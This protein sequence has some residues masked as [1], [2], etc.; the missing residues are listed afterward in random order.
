MNNPEE[1]EFVDFP[2]FQILELKEV[3]ERFGKREH[4]I[5]AVWYKKSRKG[6]TRVALGTFK[7]IKDSCEQYHAWVIRKKV[8]KKTKPQLGPESILDPNKPENYKIRINS[9]DVLGIYFPSKEI[10]ENN[11]LFCFNNFLAG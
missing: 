10:L 7:S 4:G 9:Y 11:P 2:K 5:Y 8:K 1:L 3:T 6:Q